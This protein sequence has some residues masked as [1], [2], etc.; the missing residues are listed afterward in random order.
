MAV[1]SLVAY[2]RGLAHTHTNAQDEQATVRRIL[3]L[4]LSCL[5]VTLRPSATMAKCVCL[6]P[7]YKVL[8]AKT[9]NSR[10]ASAAQ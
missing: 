2:L 6:G 7:C 10:R 1:K 8:T 4:P 3:I 5:S 9:V